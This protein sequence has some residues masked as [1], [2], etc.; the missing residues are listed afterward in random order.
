MSFQ[1]AK[2]KFLFRDRFRRIIIYFAALFHRAAHRSTLVGTNGQT[3]GKILILVFFC[4]PLVATSLLGKDFL[5]KCG[6]AI[7]H[8]KQQVLQGAS[9]F[10]FSKASTSSFIKHRDRCRS[11]Y[12]PGTKVALEIPDTVVANRCYSQTTTRHHPPH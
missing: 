5:T 3:Q 7:I 11:P 2:I 4:W 9:D 10:T 8:A 12:T 1:P 6:L